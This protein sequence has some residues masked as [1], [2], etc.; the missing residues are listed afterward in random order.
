MMFNMGQIEFVKVINP[1]F[2]IRNLVFKHMVNND[3]ETVG[4]SH[5][6]FFLSSTDCQPMVKSMKICSLRTTGRPSSFNQVKGE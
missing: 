2:T 1:Q 5:Y 6:R 4:N 3:E